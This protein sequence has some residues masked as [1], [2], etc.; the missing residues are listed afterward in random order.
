MDLKKKRRKKW[1]RSKNNLTALT[2][3]VINP[4]E[5]LRKTGV[6]GE[7]SGEM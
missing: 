1:N 2:L 5:S 7:T 3:L 4:L 6:G